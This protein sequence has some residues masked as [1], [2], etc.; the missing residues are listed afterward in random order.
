MTCP[1][2]LLIR[3]IQSFLKHWKNGHKQSCGNSFLAI[4]KSLK[5]LTRGY[6][7]P[8][9]LTT[10][11]C[12]VLLTK[13]FSCMAQFISMIQSTRP[14]LENKLSGMRI[15]DHNPQKAVVRMANL[16]VVSS[17]TVRVYSAASCI[18][19]IIARFFEI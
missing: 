7:I 5:K 18:N 15:L 8:H 19:L 16:C 11:V 10:C 13:I 2:Q 6:R 17:H 1:G 9:L 14:D 12:K 3:I 4:W